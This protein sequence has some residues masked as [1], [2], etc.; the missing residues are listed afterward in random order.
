MTVRHLA[1]AFPELSVKSRSSSTPPTFLFL[2]LDIL[3]TQNQAI[4]GWEVGGGRCLLHVFM[5]LSS[6]DY[7][8]L[9]MAPVETHVVDHSIFLSLGWTKAASK[10]RNGLAFILESSFIPWVLNKTQE[11][12]SN[13]FLS[14]FHVWIIVCLLPL[15]LELQTPPP[16]LSSC[17]ALH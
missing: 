12:N 13:A 11:R 16:S 8:Q 1:K 7:S 10:R 6:G 14:S 9:S 5:I 17:V 15:H 2:V 3:N 4:A